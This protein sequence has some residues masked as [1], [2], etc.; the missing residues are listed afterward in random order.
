VPLAGLWQLEAL[1]A[2]RTPVADAGPLAGC[3]ALLELDLAGCAALSSTVGLRLCKVLVLENTNVVSIAALA[4]CCAALEELN[5][6]STLVADLSPLA[7]SAPR[8]RKLNLS[9]TPVEDL[10]PLAGHR[11]LTHLDLSECHNLVRLCPLAGLESLTMLYLWATPVV[12]LAPLGRLTKLRNLGLSSCANVSDLVPLALALTGLEE[13]AIDNTSC[14]DLSP[15]AACAE[16]RALW[17]H[18]TNV[19][20]VSPLAGLASLRDVWLQGTQV[21]DF[22][23]IARDELRIRFDDT[24]SLDDE[25]AAV[26]PDETAAVADWAPGGDDAQTELGL[27]LGLA[28]QH[29]A[30]IELPSHDESAAEGEAPPPGHSDWDEALR[31]EGQEQEQEQEQAQGE[32]EQE[33]EQV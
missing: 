30:Q 29:V 24:E 5:L 3:L 11:A 14:T 18:N 6:A 20:D 8:L 28:Q 1:W 25:G 19:A 15:L 9:A 16:L 33:Q 10:A 7:A 23:P 32:Q 17:L 13:L 2:A 31:E 27:E 12:H 26:P 21:S 4:G 22:S